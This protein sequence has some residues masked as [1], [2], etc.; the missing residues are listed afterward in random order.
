MLACALRGPGH[1]NDPDMLEV[2]NGGMGDTE[3]RAPFSFWATLAAPL[4]AGNDLSNM[5]AA[6]REVLL[7]RQGSRQSQ[8]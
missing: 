3:D 4:M 5:S 8:G 1:W 7:A 6:T 2:G